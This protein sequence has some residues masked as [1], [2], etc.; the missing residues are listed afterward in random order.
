[1]KQ[2]W[3]NSPEKTS[4]LNK[5]PLYLHFFACLLTTESRADGTQFV[6]RDQNRLY[7]GS[8]EAIEDLEQC[9]LDNSLI[10]DRGEASLGIKQDCLF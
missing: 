4:F 10:L 8:Q 3:Q 6:F 9:K 5:Y 7:L 1:M 2:Q